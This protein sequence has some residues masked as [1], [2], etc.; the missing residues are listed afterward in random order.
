[1]VRWLCSSASHRTRS[2]RATWIAS[3]HFQAAPWRGC[4]MQ[5]VRPSGLLR[6]ALARPAAVVQPLLHRGSATAVSPIPR[7]CPRTLLLPSRSSLVPSK[8]RLLCRDNVTPLLLHAHR[9]PARGLHNISP[10]GCTQSR[11]LSTGGHSQSSAGQGG[12]DGKQEGGTVVQSAKRVD[13]PA[14]WT[15][16]WMWKALK[17]TAM[18]YYHG[19]QLLAVSQ[20]RLC[21]V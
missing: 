20:R 3:R 17:D 4:S 14:K 10:A 6:A 18:H 5:R 11:Y 1:V 13:A 7:V 8:A 9:G 2:R 16:Q 21:R 15:P 12:G 19:S